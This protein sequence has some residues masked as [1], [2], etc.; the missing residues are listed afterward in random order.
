MKTKAGLE[1][2]KRV[3][4]RGKMVEKGCIVPTYKGKLMVLESDTYFVFH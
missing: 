1:K 2:E 3:K 4:I